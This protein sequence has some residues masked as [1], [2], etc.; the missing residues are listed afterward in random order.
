M[1][2]HAVVVDS[3]IFIEHLRAK[4][5]STTTL[6]QLSQTSD[7]FI[8]SVTL[9][10]LYCGA[11]SEQKEMD[12]QKITEDLM[13][14]SLTDE[15]AIRAAKLYIQLKQQNNMIEFRD[16]FIAATCIVNDMPLITL[17]KK[18]F[19]RITELKII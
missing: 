16:I 13:V 17:N 2:I 4:N 1:E 11:T 19:A 15:V 7:I 14:L 9:Y 6:F 5:K 10:E 18:H 12:I 3:G 8:S